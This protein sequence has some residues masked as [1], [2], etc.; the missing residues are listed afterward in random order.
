MA[1]LGIER[2]GVPREV[3]VTT[4]AAKDDPKRAVIGVVPRLGYASD[5]TVEIQLDNVGG[6]APA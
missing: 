1:H 6:P 4:E 3:A 2:K 5:V